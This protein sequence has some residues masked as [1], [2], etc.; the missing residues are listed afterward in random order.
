MYKA[1]RLEQAKK[2]LAG[3]ETRL[4]NTNPWGLDMYALGALLAEQG[5]LKKE[6]EELEKE[7]KK[8]EEEE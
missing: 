6:V 7:I 4:E 8:L 3:L 5:E 2:E 1:I